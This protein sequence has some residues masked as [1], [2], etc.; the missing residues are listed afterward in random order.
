[1]ILEVY[2][3]LR[4][5]HDEVCQY[6]LRLLLFDLQGDHNIIPVISD[7]DRVHHDFS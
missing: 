4:V 2:R 5:F 3:F 1:M 7:R 6:I